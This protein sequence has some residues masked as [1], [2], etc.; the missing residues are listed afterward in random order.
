[1]NK[2][3]AENRMKAYLQKI[4][5]GPKLSKNLTENEAED[6]LSL[7][8]GGK[9]SQVRMAVFLIAAR[10]K[11]ETVSENIGYWRALQK[12]M[13]IKKIGLDKILQIADPFDGFQRIPYFGFYAIPVL[14]NWDFLF[15]VIPPYLCRPNLVS[16]SKIYWSTIIK[17]RNPITVNDGSNKFKNLNSVISIQRTFSLTWKICDRSEQKL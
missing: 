4:A 16:P 12:R 11:I 5:A 10:M 1:M 3:S 14:P 7:I 9:I 17:L 15:M 6:A 8:L 13:T 2:V